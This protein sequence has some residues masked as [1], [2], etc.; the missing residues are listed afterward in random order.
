MGVTAFPVATVRT[1]PRWHTSF[2]NLFNERDQLINTLLHG[3]PKHNRYIL[4][5][6][7]FFRLCSSWLMRYMVVKPP[8]E[9]A[10]TIGRSLCF[11]LLVCQLI[12][13][14]IIWQASA[15][16]FD[17]SFCWNHLMFFSSYQCT[18]E[19]QTRVFV[20][21]PIPTPLRGADTSPR[22]IPL[23]TYASLYGAIL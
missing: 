12:I 20:V 17:P 19:K 7:T 9:D 21:T 14:L 4:G 11:L 1:N 10:T 8:T 13:L 16:V 18:P 5:G 23:A 15:A 6:D 3:W 2:I 22:Y